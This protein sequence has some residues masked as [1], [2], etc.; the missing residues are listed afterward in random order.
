MRSVAQIEDSE[1]LKPFRHRHAGIAAHPRAD[2]QL[3]VGHALELEGFV[4]GPLEP[5]VDVE[6]AAALDPD[7]ERL[8]GVRDDDDEAANN[9]DSREAENG[10][11]NVGRAEDFLVE[12]DGRSASCTGGYEV[13]GGKKVAYLVPAHIFLCLTPGS[14]EKRFLARLRRACGN[15]DK[16]LLNCR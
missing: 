3:L 1:P 11:V 7:G 10:E 2:V 12:R 9:E 16:V 15:I 5:R 14:Y 4:H 8:D 6:V 13:V